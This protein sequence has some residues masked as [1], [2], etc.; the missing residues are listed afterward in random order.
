MGRKVATEGASEGT[1]HASEE[2]S[3]VIVEL[4]QIDDKYLELDKQYEKEVNEILRKYRALQKPFLKERHD[5]LIDA[6]KAE[7]KL[8]FGQETTGTPAIKGFWSQVLKN[9]DRMRDMIESHDCPV[10]EY[11]HDITCGEVEGHEDSVDS[12]SLS[13]HFVANPYFKNEVLVK[14]Y[15][16]SRPCHYRDDYSVD[17]IES[18]KIDWFPGKDVTVHMVAKK[19]KGGGAKKAKQKAKEEERPRESFF[20]GFLLHR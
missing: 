9:N 20:P 4:K 18:T 1:D 2:D 5:I 13:F 15:K 14:K 11:L 17:E 10:L 7:E 6:S 8:P 3:P 19:V 12:F 16:T